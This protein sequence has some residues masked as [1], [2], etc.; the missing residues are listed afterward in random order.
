MQTRSKW[1]ESFSLEQ[2]R[3]R[4][5]VRPWTEARAQHRLEVGECSSEFRH[6]SWWGQITVQRQHAS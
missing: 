6:P 4:D 3:F 5:E 1:L 2:K